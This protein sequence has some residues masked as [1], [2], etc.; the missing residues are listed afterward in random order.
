TGDGAVRREHRR[1]ARAKL[2]ELRAKLRDA[3]RAKQ[4]RMREIVAECRAQRIAVRT[5]IREMRAEAF[6][7]IRER[8]QRERTEARDA[9]LARKRQARQD[10]DSAI[11]VAR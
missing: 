4:V 9:C 5:Q 10:F 7:Q 2:A 11:A 6:R 3:L 1:L 8:A